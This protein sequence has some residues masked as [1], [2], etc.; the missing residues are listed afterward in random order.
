MKKVSI[1][2]LLCLLLGNI[3]AQRQ[4]INFDNNWKFAFG[5]ASSPEKDFNYGIRT[6]FSK[7]GGAAGTAIDPRFRDSAWRTLNLPHDWAVELPFVYKDNFDVQSHGYKP[8][9]GLFPETS[10]GWY[11]KHF[12]MARADSGYRYSIQ[13]AFQHSGIRSL[14]FT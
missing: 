14:E 4:H 2:I 12:T 7:S 9:G 11:R 8:V 10:V 1:S 5:D 13:F 3:N 6:I